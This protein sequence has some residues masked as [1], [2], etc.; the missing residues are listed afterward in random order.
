MA[1]AIREIPKGPLLSPFI[2][3]EKVYIITALAVTVLLAFGMFGS[4][5]GSHVYYQQGAVASGFLL[6]TAALVASHVHHPLPKKAHT[7]EG[8]HD[9]M[10]YH[11]KGKDSYLWDKEGVLRSDVVERDFPRN[12]YMINGE[13]LDLKPGLRIKFAGSA[14]LAQ[15]LED[16]DTLDIKAF[17]EKYRDF[18]TEI[19][20][21]RKAAY[22]KKIAELTDDPELQI[23][24]K[25]TATQTSAP[26]AVLPL[27]GRYQKFEDATGFFVEAPR[28]ASEMTTIFNIL[29]RR[30]D[31]IVEV[32]WLPSIIYKEG[33]TSTI[34]YSIEIHLEINVT[35]ETAKR[36]WK[37]S[38]AVNGKS[39][40]HFTPLKGEHKLTA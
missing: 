15:I 10:R 18:E 23:L 16:S 33:E 14:D 30:D 3:V 19:N 31:F 5:V 26:E 20:D 39:N 11:S 38:K 40:T 32:I 21:V 6:L 35:K 27:Y 36:D 13:R 2:A 7:Q 12:G 22:E 8:Y 9:Y 4:K 25:K 17:R 28:E 29:K 37:V 1:E 24:L 34:H